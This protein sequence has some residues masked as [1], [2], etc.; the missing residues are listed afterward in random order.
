M[1]GRSSSM[2]SQPLACQV[3]RT[4]YNVL[5][6]GPLSFPVCKMGL[7]SGFLHR[8]LWPLL[9]EIR[10]Q[11]RM[12]CNVPRSRKSGVGPR[13]RSPLMLPHPH[14]VLHGSLVSFLPPTPPTSLPKV[15]RAARVWFPPP[16]HTT[17]VLWGEAFQGGVP[18]GI[19]TSA[20]TW[21]V[22]R[23]APANG[24]G[25]T[26][27]RSPRWRRCAYVETGWTKGATRA[28]SGAA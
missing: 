15:C 25:T 19:T 10:A 12:A 11:R 4:L 7:E 17:D 16:P 1:T 9:G 24:A 20:W 23:F 21:H 6:V 22:R 13:A 14:G 8:V 3:C 27:E 18:N 26:Q 2:R 28:P 5:N